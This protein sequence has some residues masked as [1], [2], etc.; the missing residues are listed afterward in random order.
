MR[1]RNYYRIRT[2]TRVIFWTALLIGIYLV[3]THV[4]WTGSGWTWS[5]IDPLLK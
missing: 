2:L 4:W 1:S 3:A 5:N